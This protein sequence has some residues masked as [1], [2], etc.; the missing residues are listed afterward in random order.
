M[1]ICLVD[2]TAAWHSF[3]AVEVAYNHLA[4]HVSRD[5]HGVVGVEADSST[6]EERLLIYS[7]KLLAKH[8]E[9]DQVPAK[10]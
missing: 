7:V 3:L 10:T 6:A 4:V 5:Y 2:V 1:T 8:I 9:H